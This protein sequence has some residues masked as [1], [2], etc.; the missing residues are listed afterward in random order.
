MYLPLAQIDPEDCCRYQ[1]T[2]AC[3]KVYDL[4]TLGLAG[5]FLRLTISQIEGVTLRA[6]DRKAA[7]DSLSFR[8]STRARFLRGS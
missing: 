3:S 8:R 4:A 7:R 5:Q 6:S 1:V 2:D